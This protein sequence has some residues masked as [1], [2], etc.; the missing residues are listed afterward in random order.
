MSNKFVKKSKFLSLV[1][2]HKPEAIG[3]SLDNN[4]Y[5]FV[6]DILKGLDISQYE[7]DYIVANDSKKRYS[8]NQDKTKIRANQGHSINVDL[9]FKEKQPPDILYHGTSAKVINKIFKEGIMKM[10]RQYVHLSFDYDTAVKVGERH[11]NP[12]VLEIN[13]KLMYEKGIKFF[14]SENGVWLTEYVSP[15]YIQIKKVD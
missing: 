8:Y 11:G 13:S 3:I 12:V 10:N 15:E 7:L 4:G 1:L 14:I 2:R 9:E 5:A 6:K